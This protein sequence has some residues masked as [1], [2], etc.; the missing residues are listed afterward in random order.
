[1]R[2]SLK[3]TVHDSA[4]LDVALLAEVQLD[5]LPEAA[6]VVVVDG[7]GV[8]KGLHDGTADRNRKYERPGRRVTVNQ[9]APGAPALQQRL[10]HVGRPV[11]GRCLQRVLA[12]AGQELQDQLGAFRFPGAALSAEG[13]K[14]DERSNFRNA[15]VRIVCKKSNISNTKKTN[16]IC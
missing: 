5:E 8:S 9:S 13:S 2:A 1:M 7:L 4:S 11:S 6:G 12:H 15:N 10:L 16:K 3:D 14:E